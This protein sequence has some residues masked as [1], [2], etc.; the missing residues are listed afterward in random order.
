MSFQTNHIQ[1]EAS[2]FNEFVGSA[3]TGLMLVVF[4][5]ASITSVIALV[6]I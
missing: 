5:L 2:R 3:L 6:H 4:S 1:A